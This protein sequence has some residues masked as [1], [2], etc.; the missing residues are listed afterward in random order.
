VPY[1]LVWFAA[2]L[3]HQIDPYVGVTNEQVEALYRHF[4]LLVR[5]NQKMNLTAVRNPEEM[6][7]RH[8]C[9]SLFFA[10]RIPADWS[11]FVDIGSGAGF[12]GIPMAILRPE[13]RVTLLE[14]QQRKAVF[15]R[16]ATRKLGNVA[17]RGD[18]A[19]KI[20]G[21]FRAIVSRAVDPA[22]VLSLLPRLSTNVGLLIGDTELAQ[23]I[24]V[25]SRIN[26]PW[27]E[28]R[29]AIY[30]SVSRGTPRAELPFVPCGT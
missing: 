12:P 10:S 9:E 24:E 15:L 13:W 16:E 6:V 20:T 18:R 17:V 21:S 11:D 30:A 26:L 29:V 4:E 27:G 23:D 25:L 1:D 19:E 28:K 14:A 22:E 5:W 7:V 2:Q 3:H 8:Y